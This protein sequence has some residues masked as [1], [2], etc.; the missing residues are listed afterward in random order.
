MSGQLTEGALRFRKLTLSE[1]VLLLV[2]ANVGAAILSL[3]YAARA[4][5][6]AGAVIVSV[7]TTLFS[8]IS[9]LY[10][11]ELMLRTNSPGQLVGLMRTYMFNSR[12]GRFYLLLMSTL[13]V[14]LAIPSLTAYVIGGGGIISSLFELPPSVGALLFLLP[15]ASIV[16]LGLKATGAAQKWASIA[17]GA[18]LVALTIASIL[19]PGF[20][21]S[22]LSRF[23]LAPI[24]AI[25]P[26]GVFTSM[27]HTIVPE[28]V[29]GLAYEPRLIPRAVKWGLGI[30]LLFLVAFPIAIFGLQNPEQIS[31]VVTISWGHA[32]GPVIY[33]AV[34]IF[35][36]LALVTSFWGA[37]GAS[38]GNVVEILR[39]KSEWNVRSRLIAFGITVLPSLAIVFA[40]KLGFLD[41]IQAAG[42]VGGVILAVLPIF[43]LSRARARSE[44]TP[45][46]QVGV[47]YSPVVKAAL[48]L[49]YV[50]VLL[51]AAL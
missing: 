2:G 48:L 14:G 12:Y 49:F 33:L 7:V 39:F 36:L 43:V 46:Y 4:S 13:T 8:L 18:A 42:A 26:V 40:G 41:M 21:A 50:G 15:G 6:Y 47:L 51:Y 44:R 1:A 16:W 45:E 28:V 37:A 35:A 22:R 34:N 20:D 10:I 17:M 27:S 30:N 5:G 11:V 9:H 23:S 31:E 24:V 29:R 32:L 25:L 38:L 19:H 3:P